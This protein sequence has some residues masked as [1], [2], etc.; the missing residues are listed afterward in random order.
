[1][2][3]HTE[4]FGTR[5]RAALGITE[6]TDAVVVVVSEENGQ[7]SLVE[8][9]RIVRNLSEAA[10]RLG[11]SATLLAPD[12]AAG[13][14]LGPAASAGRRDRRPA[15]RASPISGRLRGTQPAGPTRPRRHAVPR[16]PTTTPAVAPHGRRGDPAPRDSSS[17]T[18][19]SSWRRSPSRRSSTPGLVVS[20][21]VVR[22]HR[23][24][25]RSRR[26]TSRPTRSS[27]SNLPPVTRDPVPRSGDV[28]SPPTPNSFRA[29]IDLARTSTRSA[30]STYVPVDVGRSIRGSW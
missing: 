19:R 2:T 28:G 1:M 7:V 27:L 17:T 26:S 3:V 5:H 18:G 30:G 24:A 12:R 14:R 20:Q 16:C 8:R 15:R 25:S 11:R 4:R 10:A 9:A 23:P 21:Y 29:T 6:Q 22:L 13:G